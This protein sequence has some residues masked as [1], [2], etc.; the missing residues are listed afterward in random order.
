MLVPLFPQF[1]AAVIA[2]PESLRRR[3]ISEIATAIAEA[4][5]ASFPLGFPLNKFA[6]GR[7]GEAVGAGV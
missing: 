6:V 7:H 3:K 4:M 5:P 2:I 1:R